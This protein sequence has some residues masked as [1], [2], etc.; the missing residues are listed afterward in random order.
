MMRKSLPGLV[1]L[2]LVPLVATLVPP[3]APEARSVGKQP[4]PDPCGGAHHTQNEHDEPI[5]DLH[6][7]APR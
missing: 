7:H 3:A 5:D 2:A 1:L 4:P 6:E